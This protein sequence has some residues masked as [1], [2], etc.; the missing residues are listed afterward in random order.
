MQPDFP[1][2]VYQITYFHSRRR[3]YAKRVVLY[4]AIEIRL[5]MDLNFSSSLE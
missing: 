4:T 5:E 1:G 2:S 3:K